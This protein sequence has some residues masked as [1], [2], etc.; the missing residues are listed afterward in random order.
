MAEKNLRQRLL[1]GLEQAMD[2]MLPEISTH[3]RFRP[4]VEDLLPTMNRKYPVKIIAHPD[5]GRD[6]SGTTL[7]SR[8]SGVLVAIGPE[9]GWSDFEIDLFQHQDFQAFTL[10]PRILRVDT[11]VPAI[12][13]QLDLLRSQAPG[14]EKA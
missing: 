9:G 14:K 11:A 5:S 8:A 3:N 7:P 6:I 2:T 1:L 12:L 10:G 13:S 4:F